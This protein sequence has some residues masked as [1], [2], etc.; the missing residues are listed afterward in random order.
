VEHVSDAR[1][2][3]LDRTQPRA[4]VIYCSDPRFQRA[5]GEFIRYDLGLGEG[6]YIP[7]VTP[8]GVASFS[9]PLKLPKEFKFMKDR[10]EFFFQSFTSA[11]RIILINHEDC[12]HYEGLKSFLGR[13]FLHQVS[14]MGERQRN[15]LKAVAKM[16]LGYALPD[17]VVEL[18]YA[19]IHTEGTGTVVFEKVPL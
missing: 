1:S 12:R 8:G 17:L 3:A 16:L 15:D 13:L 19:R 18:Y 2:Y 7:L 11:R 6:E 4:I 5:F 14:S 9:E 10:L